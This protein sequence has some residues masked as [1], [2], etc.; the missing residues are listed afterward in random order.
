MLVHSLAVQR[1][2]FNGHRFGCCFCFCFSL[3]SIFFYSYHRKGLKSVATLLPL[4]GVTW[5]F[6]LFI[7]FHEVLAYIFILLTSTQVCWD[8]HFMKYNQSCNNN[9]RRLPKIRRNYTLY[10]C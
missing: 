9:S 1:P 4:L 8:I 2:F 5:L 6:G 10:G 7:D 3:M